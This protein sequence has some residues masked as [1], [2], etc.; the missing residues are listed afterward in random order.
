[1]VLLLA[2]IVLGWVCKV[3]CRASQTGDAIKVVVAVPVRA[4]QLQFDYIGFAVFAW[5]GMMPASK[6]WFGC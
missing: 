5:K 6:S 4:R 2:F 1:M 3:Y